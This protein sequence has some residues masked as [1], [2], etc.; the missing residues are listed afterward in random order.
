M[1]IIIT[2]KECRGKDEQYVATYV[3]PHCKGGD[4][5][6]DFKYCPSCQE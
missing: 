6:N 5:Q 1:K 4:I 2:D 3:C